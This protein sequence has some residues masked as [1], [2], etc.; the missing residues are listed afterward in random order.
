MHQEQVG[1]SRSAL[2]LRLM[3]VLSYEV[4]GPSPM[5]SWTN[6]WRKNPSRLLNIRQV[7]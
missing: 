7:N 3:T 1:D 6:S 4:G 2:L 5:C